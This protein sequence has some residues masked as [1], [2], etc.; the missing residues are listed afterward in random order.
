MDDLF[1][2]LLLITILKDYAENNSSI[3]TIVKNFNNAY[4]K[5]N[6]IPNTYEKQSGFILNKISTLIEILCLKKLKD[7]RND[8]LVLV[9][10]L[11]ELTDELEHVIKEVEV[12]VTTSK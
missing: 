11:R 6:E 8:A 1:K 4:K 5:A 10:L 3:D 2:K 12:D 7:N 9:N